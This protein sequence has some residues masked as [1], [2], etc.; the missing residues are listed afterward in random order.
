MGWYQ[1]EDN[2]GTTSDL[3]L[4]DQRRRDQCRRGVLDGEG[5]GGRQ[6]RLGTDTRGLTRVHGCHS[7]ARV[8][9]LPRCLYKTES[10]YKFIIVIC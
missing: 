10:M 1:R 3:F 9:C 8:E 7:Q 6:S 5:G 2:E 4:R